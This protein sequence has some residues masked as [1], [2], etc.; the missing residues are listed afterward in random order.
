[1]KFIKNKKKGVKYRKWYINESKERRKISDNNLLVLTLIFKG[2]KIYI[3][4]TDSWEINISDLANQLNKRWS[5]WSY[6]NKSFIEA[7]ELLEGKP[8]IRRCKDKQNKR[9]IQVFVNIKLALKILSDYSPILFFHVF[10][11]YKKSFEVRSKSSR[12]YELKI[13]ELLNNIELLGATISKLTNKAFKVDLT[14][15]RYLLYA[16]ECNNKVKFG[17]SFK[18]KKGQRPKSHRTSVPNFAIGFVIYAEKKHLQSFNNAVKQNL[19]FDV[20]GEFAGCSIEE[21]EYFTLQYF[22][23][24]GWKCHKENIQ[25]IKLLNISLAN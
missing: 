24:M 23:T 10:T 22:K 8:L 1:M 2:R 11:E 3:K 19:K 9:K 13:K 7:L 12:F 17:T 5:D 4:R 20:K 14:G 6:N 15:G 16:Y 25:K 21:F 18:N